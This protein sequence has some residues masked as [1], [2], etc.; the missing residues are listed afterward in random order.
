[1][2]PIATGAAPPHVRVAAVRFAPGARTAW[3]CH[4]LGQTLYV[5]DGRGRIQ[6]RDGEVIDL[7]A[8]DVVVAPA[9]EWHWHGAAPDRFMSHLSITE[10]TQ[11]GTPDSEWGALVT[12]AE[13]DGAVPPD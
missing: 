9:N 4:A 12:D 5:T 11:D 2:D 8:G 10:A 6:S 3:H 1:M 7:S 13:Y